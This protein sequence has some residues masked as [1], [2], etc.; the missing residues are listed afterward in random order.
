MIQ[1]EVAAQVPVR[2]SF[3][4]VVGWVFLAFSAMGTLI[5]ILQ[6]TMLATVFPLDEMNKATSADPEFAKLPLF[7]RF[8]MA[9]PWL[10]FALALLMSATTLVAS[11]GLLR[12]KNWARL[13]FI[14]ILVLGVAWT[15]GSLPLSWSMFSSGPFSDKNMPEDFSRFLVVMQVFMAV[16]AIG[17]AALFAWIIRRLVS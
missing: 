12:R 3:V 9:H 16:F 14:G 11:I 17:F 1:S 4:T 7:F 5:G 2:S 10:W 8:F 13:L 15:V 6:N